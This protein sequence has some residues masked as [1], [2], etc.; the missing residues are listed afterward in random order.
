[1]GIIGFGN[2]GRQVSHRLSGFDCEVLYYDPI[3]LMPGRDK[4]L[5]AQTVDLDHLLQVSDTATVH[6][7]LNSSLQGMMGAR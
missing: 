1:V 2:I 7:P 4:E 5:G 6:V 3:E